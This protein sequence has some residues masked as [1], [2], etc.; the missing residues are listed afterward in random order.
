MARY[1]DACNLF[2]L[3]PDDGAPTSSTCSTATARPRAGTP[4]AIEKTI[5][6]CGDPVD[7]PDGFLACMEQYAAL[8]IELVELMPAGPQS[9]GIRQQLGDTVLPRLAAIGPR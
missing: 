3:D 6:G 2:A 1:A 5:L 8:G 7:D 4:R 9:G